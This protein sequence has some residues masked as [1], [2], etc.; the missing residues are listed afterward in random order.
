M[1]IAIAVHGGAGSA[2]P[3][4]SADAYQSGCLAAARAGYAVLTRGGSALDAVEVAAVALEDDPLFNAGTGSALNADGEV[5]MDASIME[6][7]ALDAGAVA[8]VRAVRNPIRLARLVMQRTPHVLFAGAGAERLARELGLP[9]CDP[10]SLVT[11]RARA[12]WQR[13]RTALPPPSHGTIGAVALDRAGHL[14]AATSTGGTRMKRAGRVGDSPLIG[15]GTYADDLSGACS[16]TGHGE[17]I[18]KVVLAKRACDLLRSGLSP[19]EAAPRGVLE[20]S[21]VRG[22]GGLI[23]VDRA[24]RVGVAFN[25]ARMS[26]ASID[27]AGREL[28]GFC[29]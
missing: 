7:A 14:A 6:G 29:P 4:D 27:A 15:A 3:D 24:G 19:A 20:L 23:L 25:S 28:T 1:P 8:A 11:P 10:A 16:C 21:R 2:A 22:D 18:I 13:A 26:R 17:A 12:A 5:E 9:P